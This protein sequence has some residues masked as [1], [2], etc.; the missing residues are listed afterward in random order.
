MKQY[1]LGILLAVAACLGASQ[2]A[3]AQEKKDI[4]DRL[5]TA[6]GVSLPSPYR[7]QFKEFVATNKIMC[8]EG[9]N[10]FTEQFIKD[11]MK[12]NLGIKKQNQFLLVWNAI[13]H[14]I[15]NDFIYDGSDGNEALLGDYSKV[16]D[17]ID[18]CEAKYRKDY[19][20][21]TKQR[22]AEADRRSAEAKQQSAEAK[23]KEIDENITTIKGFIKDIRDGIVNLE[24]IKKDGN[25]SDETEKSIIDFNK[26]EKEVIA[27]YDILNKSIQNN[28]TEEL[29][30]QLSSSNQL[31]SES[32]R[33]VSAISKQRSAEAKRQSAEADQSSII[34]TYSILYLNTNIYTMRNVAYESEIKKAKE[35]FKY[36]IKNF[37]EFNIDYQSLLPVEV[38]KFYDISPVKQNSLTCDKAKAN[39]LN[40]ILRETVKLYNLYQQ[41]PQAERKMPDIKGY[42]KDCKENNIDY[43]AVLRKEL[44]D[45]KKVNELLKFFGIE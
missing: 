6:L 18:A 22:S 26:R 31:V 11:Q 3:L 42:I 39:I 41:A 43:R 25:I 9:S 38:Q 17:A 36:N 23:R 21:Y 5:E 30:Q 20:A 1:L 35:Y 4:V 40:I 24:A 44:G 10:A 19:I 37:K 2:P 45:E 8:D 16:M 14:A 27:K 13:Y 32:A 15:K 28:K 12:A 29:D 34:S 33:L 7:S